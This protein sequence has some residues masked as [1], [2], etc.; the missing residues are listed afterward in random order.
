MRRSTA[1][2]SGSERETE[3]IAWAHDMVKN[4]ISNSAV[5]TEGAEAWLVGISMHS[6]LQQRKAREA[7]DHTDFK[8][9]LSHMLAA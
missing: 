8:Y 3:Q 9:G 5:T 1:R 2:D 6:G 7:P 4:V